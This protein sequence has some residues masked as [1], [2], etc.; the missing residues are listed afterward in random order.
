VNDLR[1]W[2][3]VSLSAIQLLVILWSALKFISKTQQEWQRNENRIATLEANVAQLQSDTKLLNG[4]VVKLD[5][6]SSE[7]MQLRNRL[8]GFL[9]NR[10]P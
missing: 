7:I 6:I 1:S 9:D 4:L 8:D 2:L 10:K 5:G 3:S